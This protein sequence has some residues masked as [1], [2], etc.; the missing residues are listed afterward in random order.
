MTACSLRLVVVSVDSCVAVRESCVY[1]L[2]YIEA[3][4]TGIFG[5]QTSVAVGQ[6]RLESLLETRRSGVCRLLEAMSRTSVPARF[7]LEGIEQYCRDRFDLDAVS[8]VSAR[9]RV[10]F[11]CSRRPRRLTPPS[12]N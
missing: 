5:Q 2:G 1:G 12:F 9:R 4:T 8:E 7:V 11:R 3:Q 6:E 10:L